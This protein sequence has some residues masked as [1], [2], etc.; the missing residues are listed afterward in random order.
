[1]KKHID[2]PLHVRGESEYV[3]DMPALEGMLQAQVFGSPVA[4]GDVRML[5][6]SKARKVQG[7]VRILTAEDIP[8]QNL[9][10][11]VMLDEFLLAED[12]VEYVGQPIAIV[13]ATTWEQ[14]RK[15]VLRIEVTIDELPVVTSPKEAFAKHL[16]IDEPRTFEIGNVDDAWEQCDVVVE[17]EVDIAG[18]EH[19]YLETNR[20]RAVP[21]EDKT[22]K[23]YASSQNPYGCQKSVAR[24]LGVPE[25]KVEIDVLRLGG[26]FGGKEDQGTHWAC[27][28]GLAA[29]LLKRP[30][31]LVLDRMD[32]IKMTGKR[33]PYMCD[34]KLGAMKDGTI[35]AYE[36]KHFQN[37]GA[38]ADLSTPV[39]E[40]TLFHSTNSYSIPNA[41]IFAVPCKTNLVPNTAFRG[42]GGPQGMM[43]IEAALCKAAEALGLR[44]EEMQYRNLLKDGDEFPYGQKASECRAIRTWDEL[45]T[46]YDLAGW[47]ES[48]DAFNAGH[49]VVKK[50]LALMP[51]CFGISFTKTFLNQASAL[52]LVYADGSVSVANGGVEMGQGNNSKLVNIVAATLGISDERVRCEST[53]TRRIANAAPSAASATTDLNGHASI[54]ACE[55]ILRGLRV[56]AAEQLGAERPEDIAIDDEKVWV[57]GRESDWD[58]CRLVSQAWLNRVALMAHGFFAT[59]GIHF[60][61]ET[62][63]GVPFAYHTYGVAAIEVQLDCVRGT[64]DVKKIRLVHDVGRPLNRVV[65]MGQIEGGLAQGLGWMSTEDLQYNDQ[66]YYTSNTLS[67]Y[68][69]PDVYF[70][71]DDMDVK[72]LENAE[73]RR[74]P[75]GSKAVGEPPLMYGIGLYFA[76]RDAMRAFRPD[77]VF[78][79]DTPMTPERVLMQLYPEQLAEI[80]EQAGEGS[81]VPV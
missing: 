77:G 69:V 37:S 66:G 2:A 65:D 41:R 23:V 24:I 59:P 75:L 60:D 74:G 40:R 45:A 3:D 61:R 28:A 13:I 30:V 32:D 43:V 17:G 39:L 16:V 68:K 55:K 58:W 4:H 72:L 63:K 46:G 18:Q 81:P 56:F 35:V 49:T 80:R 9:L 34:F 10:G 22:V 5:D 51:V 78:G 21:H 62:E 11:P 29:V 38:F 79:F 73:N 1:M 48:V 52:V 15:A 50:G 25:H 67:T 26:G 54:L 42:F 7:V 27:M 12:K 33:H 14:A 57:A 70:M 19:L 20:A 71:P 53:N 47:R 36:V 76:V 31:E 64:Y 44:R 6:V 8:G